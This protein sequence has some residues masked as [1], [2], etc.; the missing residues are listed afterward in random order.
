MQTIRIIAAAF[1]ALALFAPAKAQDD[2]DDL[3]VIPVPKKMHRHEGATSLTKTTNIVVRDE[4][5]LPLAKILSHNIYMQIGLALPTS[6]EATGGEGIILGL[7][8]RA[9]FR[10][11]YDL[12]QGLSRSIRQ[13]LPCGRLGSFNPSSIVG[14]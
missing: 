9:C 12:Y 3:K 6:F 7:K 4:R 13:G 14:S 10:S 8:P 11:L 1:V 5:L 2:S